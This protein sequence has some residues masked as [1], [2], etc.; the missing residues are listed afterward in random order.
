MRFIAIM[1]MK[2]ML[3]KAKNN[4]VGKDDIIEKA[5]DHMIRSYE[6]TIMYLESN[7]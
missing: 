2:I 1:I 5:Y 6:T 7:K 4:K 3:K